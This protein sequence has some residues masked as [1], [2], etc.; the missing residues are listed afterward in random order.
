MVGVEALCRWKH[1]TRG[2]IP[3]A[4]FIPIAEH[5]GLIIPLGELGAAP[6]LHRRQGLAGI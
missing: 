1:P 2:E 3:P 4:E 6:R 5:S